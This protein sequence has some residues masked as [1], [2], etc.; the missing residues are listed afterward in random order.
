MLFNLSPAHR[1]PEQQEGR[2]STGPASPDSPTCKGGIPHSC[3][4]TLHLP[5]HPGR[6][7]GITAH[8]QTWG[9]RSPA[10][11]GSL[12]LPPPGSM[13]PLPDQCQEA[14]A[15]V[16][17]SPVRPHCYLKPS[18]ASTS[19]TPSALLQEE[20]LS[21]V[22]CSSWDPG[23]TAADTTSAVLPSTYVT[24]FTGSNLH[25]A[26]HTPFWLIILCKSL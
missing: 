17:F 16:T 4:Q 22:L 6:C 14:E 20:E 21:K 18:P 25:R 11:P 7:T 9:N 26:W 15:R 19:I 3:Y 1:A 23:R 2:Q 10:S 5:L 13:Q 24:G 12:L 8:T